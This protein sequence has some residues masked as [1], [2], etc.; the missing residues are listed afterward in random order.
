M[1]PVLVRLL[2]CPTVMLPCVKLRVRLPPMVVLP[3]LTFR[4]PFAALMQTALLKLETFCNSNVPV[5]PLILI[6]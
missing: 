5:A 3:E 6:N 2:F 1:L 4:V